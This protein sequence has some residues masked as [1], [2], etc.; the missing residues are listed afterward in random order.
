MPPQLAI[1]ESNLLIQ[2]YAIYKLV[3]PNSNIFNLIILLCFFLIILIT[4]KKSKFTLLDTVHTTQLKGLAI[5]FVVVG[6]LWVHVSK[7][8]PIF[9][10]GDYAVSLFLMLSGYGLTISISKRP[11]SRD[12]YVRRLKKVMIPY[13]IITIIILFCDYLILSKTYSTIS[14]VS[15]FAGMNFS[16]ELSQL[17][18]TRWF[19][20]LLLIYYV[21]FFVFNYFMDKLSAIIMLF[22]VGLVLSLLRFLKLFPIGIFDQLIA[23]PIGCFLAY[24]INTISDFLSERRRYLFTYISLLIISIGLSLVLLFIKTNDFNNAIMKYLY[25]FIRY[26]SGISFC[27]ILILSIDFFKINYVSTFLIMCGTISYELYLIHGPIL[28]KYN[29][30]FPLF[31]AY[32]IVI[33]FFC[34]FL[35]VFIL[36]KYF[37]KLNNIYS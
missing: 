35:V 23:F 19:I 15:T 14:I 26:L 17:D 9:I 3:I 33:S 11:M 20:T 27:F 18:Y 22:F 21:F 6:H 2:N 32:L 16:R 1:H 29:F 25:I 13:W 36:S 30:I 12:F 7:D 28:I 4:F 5:L 24:Y 8:Q 31:P 10:F 34:Y 37:N